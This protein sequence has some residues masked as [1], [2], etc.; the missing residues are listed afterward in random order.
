[1]TNDDRLNELLDRW[2]ESGRELST[3]ELCRGCPELATVLQQRLDDL[4]EMEAIPAPGYDRVGHLLELWEREG[5]TVSPEELCRGCPELLPALQMRIQEAD[6]PVG[7]YRPLR[8][9]ARGG[10][11]EVFLAH[12]EE[13]HR[14]VALKRIKA[15]PFLT[16]DDRQRFLLEA[17]ITGRLEHPG[18]V[19]VYGLVQGPDGRTCY[20]MRFVRGRTLESANAE[21]HA[22]DKPGRDP[23]ERS[24]AFQKLLRAF[25][26][27]CQTVAYAHSRGVVHRDLKPANVMVDRYGETLVVDWG[28]AKPIMQREQAVT[29]EPLAPTAAPEVAETLEG[30]IKGTPAF[31]SPEQA[32][33]QTSQIG[34]AS[35]IYS[36]GAIL[37][38][39]LTSRPPFQGDN[40]GQLILQVAAGTFTPPRQVKS[41]VPAALEAVCLKAMRREPNDRYATA[42]ELAEDVEHWLADEPVTAWREPWMMQ[43]RR[44]VK[45]HRVLVSTAVAVVVVAAMAFGIATGLLTAAYEQER[46]ARNR[47][48]I[49]EANEHAARKEADRSFARA[50]GAVDRY[51]T[52]VSEDPKLKEYG[53]EPLRH[54]LLKPVADYY[55]E[56]ISERSNDPELRAELGRA[57]LRLGLITTEVGSRDQARDAFRQG[58]EILVE[59][60]RAHPDNADFRRDLAR[61]LCNLGKAWQEKGQYQEAEAAIIEA[62][63]LQEE[64]VKANPKGAEDNIWLATYLD[65]LGAQ[66]LVGNRPAE[67]V[68]I[69]TRALDIWDRVAASLPELPLPRQQRARC[70]GCLG[71]H[72]VQTG[73]MAEAENSFL[74][75]QEEL[76][77]LTQAHPGVPDYQRDLAWAI[78]NFGV[79]YGQIPGQGAKA[80]AAW[81]SAVERLQRL[82]ETHPQVVRFQVECAGWLVALGQA[83]A[84]HKQNDKAEQSWLKAIHLGEAVVKTNPEYL[85]AR[86][87]LA[88]AR[89]LMGRLYRQTR[90][91]QQAEECLRRAID[92]YEH[93]VRESPHVLKEKANLGACCEHLANTLSDVGRAEKALPWCARAFILLSEVARQNPKSAEA[94]VLTLSTHVTQAEALV[95]LKRDDEAAV[96]WERALELCQDGFRPWLRFQLA[97]SWARTKDH[98]RAFA[99]ANALAEGKVAGSHMKYDTAGPDSAYGAA[100]ICAIAAATARD[101]AGVSGPYVNRAIELLRQAS[102]RGFRNLQLVRAGMK[103]ELAILAER[104]DF[105]AWLAELEAKVQAGSK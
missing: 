17:E 90:R 101:D 27:V 15:R 50:R 42:L 53:L 73:Q 39:L 95:Q 52:Q 89:R 28:L 94:R 2:E 10:L 40:A 26:T 43:T 104:E 21:L 32:S 81:S 3:E 70:R 69:L 31:M 97:Y 61:C 72:L 71:L 45:R 30:A 93:L 25:V 7:R 92:L 19:P 67:G 68:A 66:F 14:E 11:G 74:R 33:G 82:R 37:Y 78:S 96:E 41:G 59:L 85:Q 57:Y 1:M 75:A 100:R 9:H 24:L 13:L 22:A 51:F 20:A 6:A 8:L 55:Q 38:Q 47:A 86:I 18:I 12:D 83:H 88:F 76:A 56:F 65:G 103:A 4:R 54:A 35:D 46:S 48:E 49:S 62:V 99:E 44:W 84:L 91:Y 98:A 79:M 60:A 36:L 5:R 23:G 77:E 80:E 105:K 16:L 64:L 63:R 29:G 58:Q 87:D 102:A 34:P